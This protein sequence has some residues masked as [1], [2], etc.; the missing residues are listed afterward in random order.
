MKFDSDTTP[1]NALV[2]YVMQHCD[3][4]RNH[5]D[6]NY[7][8]RWNEYERLWRGIYEE[9]DK[10]R[11]SERSKLISPAL[12]QAI[13]NKTSEIVEAVFGKG[14][15]FDIVDDLQDQDKT[16]VGLMRNQLREDFDKD[17]VRKAITHIVTLAEVYGTG[18]GELIVREVKDS[19]PATQP[20]AVPGLRMVGV[21]STNR[22]SVQL[23]PINPRN[24]LIDPNA[25]TVDE[26]LGVAIEEYV[27]R[28]SVIKAM[29]DGVYRRVYVGTA[30][31]NTD[32]EPTQDITYFQ[33]DKV[34]LLRYY[35]LVPK[36][37]LDDPDQMIGPDEEMYS[38]LVEA[39]VVIANGESLLKAEVSPFM[40][41]D[42]PV[43]AYQAD[44]V[45]NRF[46]GRGTGEKGYNMQ[47][48]T[49]AQIRSHVDSLGLTTAPMMA[50][51]AT[52]LPR[53]AKF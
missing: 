15:F 39:L 22:I 26:A 37:L 48:A 13:D 14:Q 43:V 19:R 23:K 45:P 47:K 4:W 1:Q 50:I 51:D 30:A 46:W 41:Q 21:S 44:I 7:L 28:H 5:R 49:D 35:G 25:S 17:K 18:I 27:G 36:A 11:A 52:R 20:S 6:E 38:E 40:M 16:D 33:D 34:L 24:F 42:R 31:E 3:D 2:A 8:D 29:E 12:Q 53:G 32:L 9:G 10:T